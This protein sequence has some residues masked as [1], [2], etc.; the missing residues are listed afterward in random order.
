MFIGNRRDFRPM[1]WIAQGRRVSGNMARAGPSLNEARNPVFRAQDFDFYV[2]G[3]FQ[4]PV[5]LDSV[6]FV[7]CA[8]T[9]AP[10]LISWI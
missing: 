9:I 5:F 2:R 6:D 10:A 1:D 3:I 7:R 4:A 8:V